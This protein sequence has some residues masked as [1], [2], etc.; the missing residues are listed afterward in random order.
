MSK[1]KSQTKLLVEKTGRIAELEAEVGELEEKRQ[2]LERL[3]ANQDSRI[4]TLEAENAKL[5]AGLEDI[6]RLAM[7]FK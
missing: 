5:Q 1:S 2:L 4:R 7:K 3:Y 6:I